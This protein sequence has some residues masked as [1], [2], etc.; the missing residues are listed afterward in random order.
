MLTVLKSGWRPWL[1]V[2][3]TSSRVALFQVWGINFGWSA[4]WIPSPD[5]LCRI[6]QRCDVWRALRWSRL[7]RGMRVQA[8]PR[9]CIKYRGICVT[10]EENQG[11]PQGSRK[12]LSWLALN[13]IRLVDL[14]IAG[15]GLDWPAVPCRPWLSR[16]ATGSTLGQLKYLPSCRTR[17]FPTSGNFESNLSVRA[18]MWSANSGAPRFSC[19]CLLLMYQEHQ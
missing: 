3:K 14:V 10:T 7:G 15:D 5:W 4:L 9:I 17:G 8:V 19:I 18:L 6:I 1:I 13:A 11:K 16:Q 2:L 12:A